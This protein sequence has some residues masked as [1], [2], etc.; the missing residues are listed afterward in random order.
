MKKYKVEIIVDGM[1]IEMYM[2]GRMHIEVRKK[3]VKYFQLFCRN[4][5]IEIVTTEVGKII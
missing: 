4:E 5:I 3:A 1:N 2:V